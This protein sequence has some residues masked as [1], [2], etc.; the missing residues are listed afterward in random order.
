[1][2]LDVVALTDAQLCT[3]ARVDMEAAINR[4]QYCG[5]RPAPPITEDLHGARRHLLE[6]TG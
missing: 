3:F 1:V 2:R 6:L 5:S 4:Y